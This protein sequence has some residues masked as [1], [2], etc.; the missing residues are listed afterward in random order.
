M[1]NRIVE[2]PG[3]RQR[4]YAVARPGQIIEARRRILVRSGNDKCRHPP[5]AID[6]DVEK[7]IA[8]ALRIEGAGERP[9]RYPRAVTRAIRLRGDRLG[10]GAR[11]GHQGRRPCQGIDQAPV[12][13]AAA[14]QA[15]RRGAQEIRAIAPHLALIDQAGQTAGAGQH[16][17]QRQFG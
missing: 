10:A 12:A 16:R 4:P 14:A 5:V 11:L 17:E 13:G 6:G 8:Q 15:F 3:E 1:E 2:R 9:E 7:P